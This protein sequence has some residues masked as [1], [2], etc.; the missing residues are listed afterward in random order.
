MFILALEG[1]TRMI[2][3]VESN[4]QASG[5]KVAKYAPSISH[6]MFA[7]DLLIFSKVHLLERL[8]LI[9]KKYESFFGQIVKSFIDSQE[10]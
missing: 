6:L 2:K 10:I 8:L 9:L 5:I 3:M 4:G 1:L 7:V